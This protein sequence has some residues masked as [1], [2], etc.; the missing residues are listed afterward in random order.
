MSADTELEKWRGQWQIEEVI[1]D[2]LRKN[3]ERQSRLMKL[4]IACDVL[5][6]V[7]IGG[8][9]TIWAFRSQDSGNS[10]VAIASWLFLAAAWTAVLILNRGLWVPA[11]L[12]SS[13]YLD[14]SVQRCQGALKTVWFAA[15]LF[16]I[17]IAFGLSWA[18]LHTSRQTP[19]LQWLAFSS[20]RIDIVWMCTA[21]FFATLFWYRNRKRRE[22]EKLLRM[23]S[24]VT[25]VDGAD[26]AA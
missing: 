13:A 25:P 18:Y 7:I 6:T 15:A 17:E 23:V 1:P 4:G 26:G 19:V 21:L 20:L 16:L 24:E 10:L 22:L 11:A 2:S 3:V 5:V 12:D 8:G 9:S 14:L